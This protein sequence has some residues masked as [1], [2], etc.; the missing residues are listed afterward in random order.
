MDDEAARPP[1]S[2]TQYSGID[3]RAHRRAFLP[4]DQFLEVAI[5]EAD[6][7]DA[8]G[9]APEPARLITLNRMPRANIG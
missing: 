1:I 2:N 6:C 8:T 7:V 3:A 5:P 9:H 4:F